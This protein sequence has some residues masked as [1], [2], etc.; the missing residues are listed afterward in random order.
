MPELELV[1]ATMDDL[2]ILAEF[3]LALN[4]EMARYARSYPEETLVPHN[5]AYLLH[6]HLE[7]EE[8]LAWLALANGTPVGF[9]SITLHG[10]PIPGSER[11]TGTIAN[12]Y[13]VP[14][15]RRQGVGRALARHA[16]SALRAVGAGHIELQFL[17]QNQAA[18]RFW[19]GLGFVAE[20]ITA[21]LPPR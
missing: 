16:I 20:S 5:I 17:I 9:V 10:S 7:R 3:H 4:R 19:A 11:L 8:F 1:R 12:L 15:V 2:E 14:S 13:V 6:G 18:A 21:I